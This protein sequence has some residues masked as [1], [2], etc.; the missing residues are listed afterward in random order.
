MMHADAY[1]AIKCIAPLKA[2][3]THLREAEPV[4]CVPDAIV[5]QTVKHLPKVVADMNEFQ[6]LTGCRPGE[7]CL[8]S[9]GLVDRCGDVW[10][11]R[12]PNHKTAYRH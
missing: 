10:E 1:V 6:Q 2:R 7:V 8:V 11:V 5:E 3:R 4:K 12:L 9:R